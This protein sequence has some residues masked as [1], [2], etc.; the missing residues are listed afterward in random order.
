MAVF[1]KRYIADW[2][3]TSRFLNEEERALLNHRLLENSR[4]AKMDRLDSAA[5]Y[6]IL[7]DWK[8]Y[9]GYDTI[10]ISFNQT[11]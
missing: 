1:A 2:P 11:D 7:G 3:E 8:I 4:E 5:I 9:A 10:P 6:R